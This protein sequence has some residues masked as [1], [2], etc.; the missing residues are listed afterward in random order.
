MVA[1]YEQLQSDG[2]AETRVGAG[3]FVTAQVPRRRARASAVAAPHAV[4]GLGPFAVGRTNAD[5]ALLTQFARLIR[6]SLS[7][8]DPVHFGYGDAR[9]SEALRRA[10]AGH[11]ATTRGV[12]CDP[13]CILVTS[14]TQQAIRL[15]AETLLRPGDAVWFEDPGYPA[16]RRIFAAVGARLVPVLVDQAGLDVSAGRRAAA[17][18]VAAYVTPSHQF[19]T[20]VTMAMERRVALLDWAQDT[21]GWILEDDYD[22]EFRYAGPP[23]TALAGIDA[24]ARVIYLGSFSKTLFPG[25][26]IGYAVLPP[27]LLEPVATARLVADRFPPSLPG[28]ALAALILEGGFAAHVRR[29]RSR[30]RL[31]RDLVAA[32][33]VQASGGILRVAVPDQGLHLVALLPPSWPP[34]AAAAIRAMAGIEALLLSETR[35]D[36]APQDGFV[37]GF[38][39]HSLAELRGAGER[40]GQAVR[41]WASGAE[42]HVPTAAYGPEHS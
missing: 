9:G 3:T 15:C 12:V 5:P 40:L 42:P 4:A 7:A 36:P 35:I 21:N 27:V 38:S 32:V 26:R 10:I 22:S 29:M 25:L 33:V 17:Q 11:L 24:H 1:A 23:L 28:E 37:L 20:G 2:L 41:A 30:Y 18:A 16:A 6:R 34:N 39:G 8:A 14:G 13:A 31:A 19:P